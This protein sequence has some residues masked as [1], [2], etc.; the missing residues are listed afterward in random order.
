MKAKEH[1]DWPSSW[2]YVGG[3]APSAGEVSQH[4]TLTGVVTI[5][6]CRYQDTGRLQGTKMHC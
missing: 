6:K 4:G 3:A 5:V 1:K 2:A